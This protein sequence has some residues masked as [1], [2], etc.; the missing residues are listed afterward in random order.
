MKKVN[1]YYSY[2]ELTGDYE[3][4]TLEVPDKII[5][6]INDSYENYMSF[7]KNLK[8]LKDRTR[9]SNKINKL[10]AEYKKSQWELEKFIFDTI[11]FV[12]CNYDDIEGYYLVEDA[13]TEEELLEY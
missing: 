4:K 11:G 13:E 6:V 5:D 10:L 7:L 3:V 1:I 2:D 9:N 12:S 8:N